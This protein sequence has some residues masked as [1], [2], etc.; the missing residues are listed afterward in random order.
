MSEEKTSKKVGIWAYVLIGAAG[1]GIL[2][3]DV[4]TLWQAGGQTVAKVGE[5]DITLSQLNEAVSNLQGS[6][7]DLPAKTLQEQALHRLIGQ[8]LLEEHALAGNFSYPD[9]LIH[10][11]IKQSFDSDAAYQTWLRE[12]GIS[13]RSY[14]ETLRRIGT[15]DSYYQTLAAAAPKDDPLLAALLD[16]MAQT[17]DY[18]AVRLALAPVADGIAIDEAAVKAWYDAHPED[19]MT[20]EVVSVR[21]VVLD[22]ARLAAAQNIDAE[23]LAAKQRQSERRAGQYLIFDD[24][25]AADAALEAFNK[26][27]KTFADIAADIQNGTIAGEAGELPLQQHGK[28]VDPVADD[29]LFA[30][31][32]TGDV[33]PVLRSENFN[34]MILTLTEREESNHD[35]LRDTLANEL[36][37][38]RYGELAAK[39]FDAALENK[40]LNQI[41][42]IVGEDIATADNLT[43]DSAVDWL[44][45]AKIRLSLF[46]EHGLETGKIAEPVELDQGR[47]IFYEVTARTLPEQ[48][49]Y[50]DVQKDVQAAWRQAEAGKILDERSSAIENAWRNGEDADA[51]IA[52]YGGERRQ[53]TGINPLLPSEEVNADVAA[54][55]MRQSDAV[56]S[57]VAENGDRLIT[58]LD[59]VHPGDRANL[60]ADMLAILQQQQQ[61]SARQETEQAMANWLQQNGS[62]KIYTDRLPQP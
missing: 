22:R 45:N 55:L 15:V 31:E 49:P 33:S 30:L 26:G 17:R 42:D 12:R 48:R 50:A 19:F 32:K 51:L 23:T 54:E 34:A 41:A 29:A 57:T 36:A 44:G 40:P 20:P 10:R 6:L 8:A 35:N 28:G 59:A 11:E 46:G 52:Q 56:T 4:P 13:A 39:A 27:E 47:S 53:Y 38:A 18:T 1:L 5:R 37:E 60:P 9:E 21:Y 24:R 58:H 25:S 16:D 14:Q 62:V 3:F 7:P 43:A 2:M 61:I